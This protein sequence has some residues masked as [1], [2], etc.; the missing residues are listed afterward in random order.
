[1]VMYPEH[2]SRVECKAVMF[3]IGKILFSTRGS[4]FIRIYGN[5]FC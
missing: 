1:M 2:Y 5:R 3:S 4:Y